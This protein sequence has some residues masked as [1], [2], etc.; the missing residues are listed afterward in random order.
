TSLEIVRRR[1]EHDPELFALYAEVFGDGNLERSRKRYDWQYFENPNTPEDGPVIWMAREGDTLL[2]QMATMP[3]PMWW[4][5]REVRASAGNDY[6][7]RKSAQGRGIGIALSNRWA[8]EVDVALALG[9]TPSSY[10]LFRKIFTDVG[11]I[12][13]FLKILD[14]TAVARKKW[15]S[16]A[17]TFA[18]PILGLGLRVLSPSPARTAHLDVGP[19][20]AF[21]DEYD[22]LWLRARASYASCVRRD[23]RYLRWR[24]LACPFRQYRVLEARRAGTL[25]GYAVVREEGEL[26]FRRGVI[27]DLF[28]DT[29][30]LATQDALLSAALAEFAAL[31]LVRAEAYCLNRRLGEALRRQ[32]FR[33]GTTAVQYCVAYRG[34]PDGTGGPRAVLDDVANWNLFLGDGDLDRA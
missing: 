6:F 19:V 7:V 5:D 24:Y 13:S 22:D 4:G 12:P 9:L 20:T 30:D 17:G 26:S 21:T 25:S 1:P 34:T 18:G 23:A 11:P 29:N 15:G 2:G 27:A 32:G 28:C 10:P 8:D 33:S 16:V 31:N 14:S 3:F